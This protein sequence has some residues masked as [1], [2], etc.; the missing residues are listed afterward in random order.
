MNRKVTVTVSFSQTFQIDL[1]E[2]LPIEEQQKLIKDH[3]DYLMETSPA[4]PIIID[5]SDED[6]IE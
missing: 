4:E 2:T 6:L 5:C 3:A 1:D